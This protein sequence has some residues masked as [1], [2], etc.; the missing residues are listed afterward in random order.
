MVFFPDKQIPCYHCH[1]TACSWPVTHNAVPTSYPSISRSTQ[2]PQAVLPQAPLGLLLPPIPSTG[3]P[4]PSVPM[5]QWHI[6][7]LLRCRAWACCRHSPCPG[8]L[9][10]T[11]MQ[12]ILTGPHGGPKA[13]RSRG[14]WGDTG[15]KDLTVQ[16]IREGLKGK[17][18]SNWIFINELE[19]ARRKRKQTSL[20]LRRRL[21]PVGMAQDPS[22]KLAFFRLQSGTNLCITITKGPKGTVFCVYTLCIPAVTKVNM[23]SAHCLSLS[24]STKLVLPSVKS[25]H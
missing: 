6:W 5:V 23:C 16:W 10:K 20:W 7:E 14:G 4:I 8:R 13:V 22:W 3:C 17:V 1:M 2:L 9:K 21:D 25:Q 12:C 11:S 19:L 24:L 18:V 15:R